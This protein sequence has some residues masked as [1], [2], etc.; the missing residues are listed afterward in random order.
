MIAHYRIDTLNLTRPIHRL[1]CTGT[2]VVARQMF[3]RESLVQYAE[4]M[5]FPLEAV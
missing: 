2:D 1:V 5:G 4:T 3:C